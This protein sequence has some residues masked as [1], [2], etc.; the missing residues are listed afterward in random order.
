MADQVTVG[1]KVRIARE[2]KSPPWSQAD[3][4]Q[5][6]GFSKAKISMWELNRT[7]HPKRS[8]IESV[9]KACDVPIEWFYDGRPSDPPRPEAT[10]VDDP[11]LKEGFVVTV[12]VRTW[13]SAMAALDGE[14]ECYFEAIDAPH[15]IPTAFLVG[16]YR[17]VERHDL[18]NVSGRSMAPLI[19]PGDRVLFFQ[20]SSPRR[21]TVVM[22]EDPEGKVYIKVLRDV[23]GKWQLTSVAKDGAHFEDLKGWK[24]HGYA[25]AILGDDDGEGRNIRWPFGQPIKA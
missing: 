23:G 10:V 4:A 14:G 6:T 22:A 2:A 21:N 19:E 24:I 9:A 15:E 7:K 18:V 20:D 16:G 11:K 8:D 25:V 3:L 1:D 5:K 17:N 13:S 12:A